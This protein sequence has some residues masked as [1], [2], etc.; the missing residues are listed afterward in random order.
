MS[1]FRSRL[2]V[3]CLVVAIVLALIPTLIAAF[4]G[5][6]LLRSV[7]GTVAKPFVAAGTG[8][9]NAFNGFVDVFANYDELKAERVA[10][11]RA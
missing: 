8:V 2:F 5:T 3:I 10:P 6:D 11:R 9:A 1:F 7:A 4:G